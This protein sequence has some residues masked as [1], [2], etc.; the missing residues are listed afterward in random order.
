MPEDFRAAKQQLRYESWICF[1]KLFHS[2][3]LHSGKGSNFIV[4]SIPMMPWY[5]AQWRRHGFCTV[6]YTPQCILSACCLLA[7]TLIC[8]SYVPVLTVSLFSK[9]II[10]QKIFPLFSW[11]PPLQAHISH[12]SL[13]SNR[14]RFS[15]VAQ[16][17]HTQTFGWS[18]QSCHHLSRPLW[19]A[20]WLLWVLFTLSTPSSHFQPHSG[21]IVTLLRSQD[22]WDWAQVPDRQITWEC[23]RPVKWHFKAWAELVHIPFTL[24]KTA[25]RIPI[26]WYLSSVG[27]CE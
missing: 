25:I 4:L 9:G 14:D 8:S 20:R 12:W 26:H 13:A 23:R 16:L 6:L 10:S 21:L 27:F 2:C 22:T 24:E 17:V 3:L 15:H 5:Q 1:V 19:M 11:E 7:S 18:Q